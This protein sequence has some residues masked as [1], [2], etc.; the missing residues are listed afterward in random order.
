[1]SV[2]IKQ[3]SRVKPAPYTPVKMIDIKN[4]RQTQIRQEHP[5]WVYI[6]K[7]MPLLTRVSSSKQKKKSP[8]ANCA[9]LSLVRVTGLEPAAP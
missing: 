9:R 7:K 8:N 3:K 1:M 5:T 4:E 2:C 6:A